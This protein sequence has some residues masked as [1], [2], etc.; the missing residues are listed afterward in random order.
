MDHPRGEEGFE[1]T[2]F[3]HGNDFEELFDDRN[4]EAGIRSCKREIAIGSSGKFETLSTALI[5]FSSAIFNQ[6]AEVKAG[7]HEDSATKLGLC[8]RQLKNIAMAHGLSDWYMHA[9]SLIHGSM[10]TIHSG[11]RISGHGGFDL[12][13]RIAVSWL[14][15]SQLAS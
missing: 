8:L 1:G 15:A 4:N 3:R 10:G 11:K 6:L 13:S 2:D 12:W 5:R 14:P 9:T 7:L